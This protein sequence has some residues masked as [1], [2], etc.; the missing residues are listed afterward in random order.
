VVPLLA[1][2]RRVLRYDTRGAGMS[3][4]VRGPLSIGTMV[5][6][7]GGLLDALG[8]PGKVAVA[9]I[10]VGGAIALA[11]ALRLPQR[12]S[13]AVVTSPAIGIAA[14]RRA[15]VLARVASIEREGM[16]IAVED[17]MASGYPAELRG[18][19]ARFAAFRARWLGNDPASY[20]AIYRMLAGLEL[21]QK[22]AAVACPVLVV[23]GSLDR[24]RPPALVE[25]V[26]KLIPGARYQVIESGHYMAVQTP[27]LL[28][29]AIATFLDEVDPP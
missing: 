3:T 20:A 22:I 23:A 7:L 29:G 9:G 27:E 1:G 4:K 13:A 11:A 14:G 19:A 26:A 24:V 21:G 8:I 2:G 16:C 10:A 18:D 6:D 25:P 12:I 5:D 15:A 17:S 28:A